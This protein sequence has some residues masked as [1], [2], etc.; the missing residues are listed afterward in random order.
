[1]A[2]H[3]PHVT[4]SATEVAGSVETR[5]SGDVILLPM[6]EKIELKINASM[7]SSRHMELSLDRHPSFSAVKFCKSQQTIEKMG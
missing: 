7:V 6:A 2:I 1:M 4:I 3:K 5:E